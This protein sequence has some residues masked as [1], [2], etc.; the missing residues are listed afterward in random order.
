MKFKIN[1]GE[2]RHRIEIQRAVKKQN[3]DNMLVNTWEKLFDTRAKI[4]NIKGDEFLQNK[5]VGIS[6]SKKFYIRYNRNIKLLE[7]DRILYN[8]EI[9]DIKYI[10]NIEERNVYLEL[11]CEVNK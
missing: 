6:I 5:G 11:N 8:N 7:S 1:P 2:F 10:D 4:I 3:N 9:Y